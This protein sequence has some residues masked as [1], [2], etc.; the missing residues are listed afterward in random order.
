MF[1][2]FKKKLNSKFQNITKTDNSFQIKNWKKNSKFKKN[3]LTQK[4]IFINFTILQ[5]NY[6]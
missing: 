2:K 1:Q 5:K 4:W 3:G 6:Q